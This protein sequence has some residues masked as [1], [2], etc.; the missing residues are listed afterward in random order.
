MIEMQTVSCGGVSVFVSGLTGSGM[1]VCE[2][3]HKGGRFRRHRERVVAREGSAFGFRV[4]RQPLQ[5]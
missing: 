2:Y 5:Q 4:H 3:E 1:R